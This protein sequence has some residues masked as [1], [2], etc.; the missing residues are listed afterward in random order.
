MHAIKRIV[1]T[2]LNAWQRNKTD[3][4]KLLAP[5]LDLCVSYFLST[6]EHRFLQ[7]ELPDFLN[8][9]KEP[10]KWRVHLIIDYVSYRCKKVKLNS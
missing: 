9:L 4:L 5:L 7:W 1:V 2:K 10:I 8:A 6:N 3:T